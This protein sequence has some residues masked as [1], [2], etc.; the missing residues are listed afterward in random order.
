MGVGIKGRQALEGIEK[1]CG[2]KRNK[3]IITI[4]LT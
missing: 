1:A 2:F 4:E 3:I